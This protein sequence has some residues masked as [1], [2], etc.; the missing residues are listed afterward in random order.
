MLNLYRVTIK[1]YVKGKKPKTWIISA[2]N[3]KDA[4]KIARKRIKIKRI[5]K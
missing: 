3:I 1:E 2:R 4:E 5:K